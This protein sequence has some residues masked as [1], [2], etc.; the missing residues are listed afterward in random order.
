[1]NM[2]WKVSFQQNPRNDILQEKII[3]PKYSLGPKL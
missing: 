3:Q 1:M 2:S